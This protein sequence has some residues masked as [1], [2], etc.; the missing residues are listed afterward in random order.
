MYSLIYLTPLIV[1]LL[2]GMFAPATAWQF[3]NNCFLLL[4]R[5]VLI[6][7]HGL[8]GAVG[9]LQQLNDRLREELDSLRTVVG[10][11]L[12]LAICAILSASGFYI[13]TLT[14]SGILGQD[15]PVQMPFGLEML[16]GL[17]LILGLAVI[18]S[19]LLELAGWNHF[20]TWHRIKDLRAR[21]LV[22]TSAV[23]LLLLGVTTCVYLG[24]ARDELEKLT[25]KDVFTTISR[26][27][28]GDVSNVDASTNI[29]I[30]QFTGST[31]TRP[32]LILLPLFAD[33][34]AALCFHGATTGLLALLALQMWCVQV[35]LRL[36]NCIPTILYQVLEAA[37]SAVKAFFQFLQQIGQWLR[38]E[39]N[40]VS[41]SGKQVPS[42]QL[43]L[44]G[45]NISNV[46]A[47]S[48]RGE[49]EDGVFPFGGGRAGQGE[50]DIIPEPELV[51][52]DGAQIDPLGIGNMNHA[53]EEQNE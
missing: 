26:D 28:G 10:G 53:K 39:I 14:I 3:V 40:I 36:L 37:Q 50:N 1:L 16:T 33:G 30:E 5:P 18:L 17:S 20:G 25:A 42:S 46:S 9:Y 49:V 35:V 47:N 32:V 23:I 22:A 4:I 52:I 34:V 19:V 29:A 8:A 7:Q 15:V 24:Y 13:T 6:V 48:N 45:G 21:T 44:K 51:P 12:Q 27:T 43:S 38:D 2:W 11:L 41:G 31:Y